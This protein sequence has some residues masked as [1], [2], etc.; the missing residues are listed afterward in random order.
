M[1]SRYLLVLIHLRFSC[2]LSIEFLNSFDALYKVAHLHL[3]GAAHAKSPVGMGKYEL[4]FH[5]SQ[6]HK[7]KGK[8]KHVGTALAPGGQQVATGILLE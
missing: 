7:I 6:N 5:A 1:Y 4:R 2:I 8:G 3:R